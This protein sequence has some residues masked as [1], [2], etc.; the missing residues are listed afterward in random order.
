MPWGIIADGAIEKCWGVSRGGCA[1][2][3]VKDGPNELSCE[4]GYTGSPAKADAVCDSN[5]G[6]FTF[7]GG[8]FCAGDTISTCTYIYA[9][10]HAYIHT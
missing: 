6:I 9:Y 4:S 5:K 2:S 3:Y 10:I 7:I 8:E 1:V